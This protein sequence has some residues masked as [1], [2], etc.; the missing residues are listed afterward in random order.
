MRND[1]PL[2]AIGLATALALTAGCGRI[3]TPD[4][5][6]PSFSEA[7]G[8]NALERV[9]RLVQIRPRDSGSAG[10]AYA[11]QWIAQELRAI[12]LR[13]VADTWREETAQGALQFSNIFADLPGA[14]N[15][16][17]LIGSHFDTKTGLG[18]GFQGANDSG[19]STGLALELARILRGKASPLK[20][21]VRFAFF[22]GEEC[23][24][25]YRPNDGL[26]GS[27]RMA[28]QLAREQE[29]RPVAA[30]IILDMVGDRDL[31]LVIPRNV[32]P[33]LARVAL[34]A[35]ASTGYPQ[36]RI[37]PGAILDDHWPFVE[38]GMA[39][40]NLIDF[41]YGS[42]PGRNDYWHTL[43]DSLDKLS[44]HSL[45]VTGRIVLDL[46]RRIEEGADLP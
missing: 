39:A 26:H 27:R 40:L 8:T 2:R 13:P 5:G 41:E 44:A 42:S 45:T 9:E 4:S 29:Q 20:H 28:L 11:A 24:V 36:L 37:A 33:W 32:T 38:Q 31:G 1:P 15:R 12:G 6:W 10:A 43:E 17:V 22:D 23:R 30:V 3:P 7:D 46:I 35:A 34:D 25:S 14:T 18:P 19:S 21:T 16:L